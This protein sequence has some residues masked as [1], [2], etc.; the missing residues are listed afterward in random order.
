M[1]GGKGD[2]TYAVDSADDKVTEVAGQGLDVVYSGAANFTLSTNVENV[3][4]DIGGLNATGN[5]LD[6][7]FTGNGNANKLDGGVGNECSPR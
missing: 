6:N 4:M 7:K 2:D 1:I 3:V 5:T